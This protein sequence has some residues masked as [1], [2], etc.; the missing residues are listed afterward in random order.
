M[1]D[2]TLKIVF[3]CVVGLV[4]YL[5][6]FR[7][8]SHKSRNLRQIPNQ[9]EDTN[10]TKI[11]N[12]KSKS[13]NK[14]IKKRHRQS[15]SNRQ[16]HLKKLSAGILE[17]EFPIENGQLH[18]KTVYKPL[19]VCHTADYNI[20]SHDTK[21]NGK[22]NLYL[23]LESLNEKTSMKPIVHP[24]SLR[25]LKFGLQ[26][27][28]N[29]PTNLKKEILG[30]FI[31]SGDKKDKKCSH[32]K[33]INLNKVLT[34]KKRKFA[35]ISKVYL[36]NLVTVNRSKVEFV[37][38]NLDKGSKAKALMTYLAKGADKKSVLKTMKRAIYFSKNLKS[39]PIST[40][41]N[42]LEVSVPYRS[43]KKCGR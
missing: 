11:L 19:P 4:A 15:M 26:K 10:R 33:A 24:I 40:G 37:R 1:N 28:F 12:K 14:D 3:I 30:L 22:T 20:I 36:F 25:D 42:Y 23:T 29:L 18:I 38:E 41:E 27:T 17:K 2:K 9:S 7:E 31:C 13:A 43:Q 39:Y 32:K 5:V 6:F 8:T 35:N 21:V 16:Q 34:N